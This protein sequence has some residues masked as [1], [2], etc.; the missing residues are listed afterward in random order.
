MTAYYRSVYSRTLVW[1]YR[2]CVADIDIS[3]VHLRFGR[4]CSGHPSMSI[5]ITANI[6]AGDQ[7]VLFSFGQHSALREH[8][9]P[10]HDGPV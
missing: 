3:V 2:L 4:H 9:I 5:T 1:Q 7:E 6:A 8:K 10:A